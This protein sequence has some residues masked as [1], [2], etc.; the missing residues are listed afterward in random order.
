MI[1]SR[2]SC[3]VRKMTVKVI[4]GTA[5]SSMPRAAAEGVGELL[6]DHLLDRV[7]GRRRLGRPLAAVSVRHHGRSE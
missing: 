4:V 1:A 2:R 6:A 7:G 5:A 3:W